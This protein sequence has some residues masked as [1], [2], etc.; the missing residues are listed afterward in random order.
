MVSGEGLLLDALYKLEGIVWRF[1]ISGSRH[2]KDHRGILL[3]QI[4]LE[5]V[6]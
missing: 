2:N 5:P 3:F 4:V 1:P 6:K